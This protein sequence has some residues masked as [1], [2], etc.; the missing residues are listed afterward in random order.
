MENL[1]LDDVQLS[2]EDED[3]LSM[4]S[5]TVADY[6]KRKLLPPLSNQQDGMGNLLAT[7][8]DWETKC[9]V[10]CANGDETR[11]E[12]YNE[13]ESSTKR[14]TWELMKM[15]SIDLMCLGDSQS[16][17][18]EQFRMRLEDRA[19]NTCRI[20]AKSETHRMHKSDIQ[21]VFNRREIAMQAA[22]C[23]ALRCEEFQSQRWKTRAVVE[24][25]RMD[26]IHELCNKV[27]RVQSH[28]EK[29][30]LI[31]LRQEDEFAL[32]FRSFCRESS[33]MK[34]SDQCSNYWREVRQ[35]ATATI[36][37]ALASRVIATRFEQQ[38]RASVVLQ[39]HIRGASA[40]TQFLCEYGGYPKQ[41]L[42]SK[43]CSA[44]SR[45]AR[46]LHGIVLRKRFKRLQRH[47]QS[48]NL[49]EIDTTYFHIN[50]DD[51]ACVTDQSERITY[52]N[53][54]ESLH[55]PECLTFPIVQPQVSQETVTNIACKEDW[56][57]SNETTRRLFDKAKRNMK[58]RP[59]SYL[60]N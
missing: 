60:A 32:E 56:D 10:K 38:L 47:M 12:D 15:N 27:R 23:S 24:S 51:F 13:R 20:Y 34:H 16:L 46:F 2:D 41:L 14:E 4:I 59:R 49:P 5:L 19:A 25:V 18:N 29:Y 9:I 52:A 57:F 3:E 1:W 58:P 39:R 8:E 21:A 53:E 45:I 28:M 22:E 7:N 31:S 30:E 35:N 6:L 17:K 42:A 11:R 44:T 50:V 40:R 48:E 54:F 37:K 43:R 36:V 55:V 26:A 33:R